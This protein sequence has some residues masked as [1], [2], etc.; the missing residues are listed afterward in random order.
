M[1][2]LALPVGAFVPGEAEP[3]EA[4]E[5]RLLVLRRGALD[6]GILDSKDEDALVV[7]GEDPVEQGRP[8]DT[9]V[10]G[11]RGAGGESYPNG[12]IHKNRVLTLKR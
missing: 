10:E 3:G 7:A 12:I 6:V 4:I 1:A 9:D 5:D 11:P 2:S 8:R